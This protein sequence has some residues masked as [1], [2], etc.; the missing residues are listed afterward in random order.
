MNECCLPVVR[1]SC[2]PEAPSQT[3]IPEAI[4]CLIEAT[5]CEILMN[6]LQFYLLLL[7]LFAALY[8]EGM[9]CKETKRQHSY[10]K[11]KKLEYLLES[12]INE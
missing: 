3:P 12:I 6:W 9:H 4:N 7:V 11:I 8:F 1:Q 2:G 10:I 5:K